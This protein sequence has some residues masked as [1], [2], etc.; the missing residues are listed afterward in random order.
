MIDLHGFSGLV[1]FSIRL[2]GDILV[3]S[4]DSATGKTLF[5]NAAHDVLV[6]HYQVVTATLTTN[7][8]HLLKDIYTDANKL[9]VFDRADMW[10][11]SEYRSVIEQSTSFNKFIILGRY[12]RYF[13]NATVEDVQLLTA[14]CKSNKDLV[15]VYT[16]NLTEMEA[17]D[18][19]QSDL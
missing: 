13:G 16:S 14:H 5:Y 17:L 3:I 15:S 9:Y 1:H 2:S 7:K 18:Y 11:S 19:M 6:S 4:G 12:T 8:E 10:L